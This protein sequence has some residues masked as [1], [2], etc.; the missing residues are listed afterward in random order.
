MR[1]N[2][3]INVCQLSPMKCGTTWLSSVLA[4]HPDV[5]AFNL[6]SENFDTLDKLTEDIMN[7][8]H[9]EGLLYARRNL[10]PQHD[11]AAR[12]YEHNSEMKFVVV[13]R[14]PL[15]RLISHWQHHVVKMNAIGQPLHPSINVSK[16]WLTNCYDINEYLHTGQFD[17][18]N[19]PPFLLKSLYY[20]NLE[21]YFK[22]FDSKQFLVMTAESLFEFPIECLRNIFRFCGISELSEAQFSDLPMA[23]R[24]TA[25]DMQ[26]K[27]SGIIPSRKRVFMPL[28]L[29]AKNILNG[30]FDAE[31]KKIEDF[32][33]RKFDVN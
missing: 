29:E 7:R 15:D 19:M 26:K 14:D 3:K 28:D 6:R 12:L 8:M 21:K 27:L 5:Y 31:N 25:S 4:Q 22:L 24:N 1:D 18:D 30:V 13:L 23:A 17:V 2:M 10:N 33:G 20:M 11:L 9:G 16:S 32:L